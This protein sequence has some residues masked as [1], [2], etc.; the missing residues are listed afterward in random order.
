[1]HPD[2]YAESEMSR[3]ALLLAA[4]LVL[5]V[6]ACTGDSADTPSPAASIDLGTTT[7]ADEQTTP[8]SAETTIATNPGTAV[9]RLVVLDGIGDIF[10]IDPDGSNSS[11]VTD[12]GAAARHFQPI[13]SPVTDRLVWGEASS[14]G[15]GVGSSAGDG[16]DERLVPTSSLP[17]Y[18]NWSPDGSQVG[19]LYGGVQG[20]V[21][22]VVDMEQF[23]SSP[24]GSGSPFYFSW[25]PQ[26]TGMAVHVGAND[27]GTLVIGENLID[28]GTTAAIYQAPHWT[29]AGIFHF[30]EE[31]LAL[32]D[33]SGD[34][35]LLATLPGEPV[36]FVANPQGTKVAIESFTGEEED[37]STVAFS[38]S[39]EINA[40]AVSVLDVATGD[41]DIA[42]EDTSVG[43]FWSP[44][45]ESLLLLQLTGETGEVDV[46]VW[47]DGEIS[48]LTTMT[49]PVSFFREVLQYFNQYAQSLQLWSPDSSAVALA[50]T[51][52]D[53][54]GVWVIPTDGSDPALVFEG[55]WVAWSYG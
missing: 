31:G 24:I 5:V 52:G 48:L 41:V 10:T 44:D 14:A 26:S 54:S 36:F 42:S 37:G 30:D 35:H 6:P 29:P 45:G 18:L 43:Y 23:T 19:I 55:A 2:R 22:E 8:T 33:Q 38:P 47:N 17:F 25:N 7:P 53:E 20:V 4:V 28:L 13:W 9:N 11:R 27:F 46:S 1:M 16:S 15:F 34:E 21:L 51:I 12:D 3:R 50:G 39:V 49:P 40:D 32:V